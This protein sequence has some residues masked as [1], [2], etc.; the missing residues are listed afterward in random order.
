MRN[1]FLLIY[2]YEMFNSLGLKFIDCK[3]QPFKLVN[4]SLFSV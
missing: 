3:L 1:T 4:S 2:M